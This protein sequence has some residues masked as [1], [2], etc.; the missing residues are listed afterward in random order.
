MAVGALV[1]A[2]RDFRKMRFHRLRI[3]I[4]PDGVAAARFPAPHVDL[5]QVFV[6][7][8][9]YR[10]LGTEVLDDVFAFFTDQ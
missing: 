1:L 6:M 5:L 3:G 8:A 10:V 9:T 4:E 7:Q 2:G